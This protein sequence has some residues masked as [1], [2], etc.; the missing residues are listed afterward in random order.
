[1]MSTQNRAVLQHLKN[2]SNNTDVD[3]WLSYESDL[4]SLA[5]NEKILYKYNEFSGEIHSIIDSLAESGYIVY[6]SN[7]KHWF[8]LTAKALHPYQFKASSF[9]TWFVDKSIDIAALIIS[10]IALIRTF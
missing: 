8:S 3:L 5:D 6:K 7:D 10:I 2:L 4:I 9:K 1:M